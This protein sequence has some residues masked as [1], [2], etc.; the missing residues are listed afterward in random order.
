MSIRIGVVGASGLVGRELI[1]FLQ[2]DNF[3]C[4]EIRKIG[5]YTREDIIGIE[6]GGVFNGLDYVIFCAG[7]AVS[8]KYVEQARAAGAVVIDCSSA[9][10]MDPRVPLIIPEINGSMLSLESFW[11]NSLGIIANPNCSTSIALMGLWPLHRKFHLKRFIAATYQAVSGS[12]QAGVQDLEKQAQ[13]WARGHA[14]EPQA[15]DYP[16]AFN[17]FPRVG[18]VGLDG[19]T[20]EESKMENETRKILGLPLLRVSTTCVRVPVW[21]AHS[22]AIHAEFE[23]PVDLGEARAILEADPNLNYDETPMPINYTRHKAC[24]VGRLRKDRM[25][26]N[27]LALWVVGDQLWRGAALNAFRI[28]KTCEGASL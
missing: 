17:L 5:S 12:G 25:F 23:K 4:Q 13:A 24:G 14:C 2:S 15:Y 7:K 1:F 20:E 8:L 18:D 28:L 27:G 9:F 21:R 22:I 26:D 6:E 3:G 11:A 16:I 19:Y 10:R